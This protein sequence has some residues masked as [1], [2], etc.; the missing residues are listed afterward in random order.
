MNAFSITGPH[1]LT[2]STPP[3]VL[4]NGVTA[5]SVDKLLVLA[6]SSILAA[7]LEGYER[8]AKAAQLWQTSGSHRL[9]Y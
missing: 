1:A 6:G 2:A 4:S 8:Q 9:Q 3:T 5:V 7:R